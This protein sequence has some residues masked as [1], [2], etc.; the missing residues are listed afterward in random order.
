MKPRRLLLLAFLLVAG[1]ALAGG[2]SFDPQF[3]QADLEDLTKAMGDALAFP[4]LGPANPSGLTG[5][6]VLAAG[7]GPQA[8][9]DSHWFKHG[10]DSST[11][12]GLL[13]GGRVIGR[14]GLPG[15][16]DVG[17]QYGT[18]IGEKFW[19]A[20]ARWALLAGGALE[21]AVAFRAS[22]SSLDAGT[23]DFQVGEGQLVLSK[24]FA[25]FTPYVMGGWRRVTGH[26]TFGIAQPERHTVTVNG[27]VAAAGVRIGL[28]PFRIVAEA[29]RGA[30]LG[31]FVGV[32]VG[33]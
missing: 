27:A 23:A 14:K 10:V 30:E 26:A 29:R 13:A 33:L 7:G 6:E 20:E 28:P 3:T 12:A 24:G 16:L 9:S 31:F 25:I 19:G 15:G 11:V 1:Q 5:F 32:G 17:A 4:N 2:F 22:Y 21:P 8:D 18:L